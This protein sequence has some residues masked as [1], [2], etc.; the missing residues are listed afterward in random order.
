[1]L[2][3]QSGGVYVVSLVS[4]SQEDGSKRCFAPQLS[5][6]LIAEWLRMNPC[7]RLD[8]DDHRPTVAELRERLAA[9]WLPHEPVLYVGQT[10]KSLGERLS[11]YR[12]TPPERS[13]P[14]AGGYWLKLVAGYSS[15]FVFWAART[16]PNAAEKAMLDRFVSRVSR[17][18]RALLL[19]PL[20]PFPFANLEHPKG[21][22]KAHG[23]K[24]PHCGG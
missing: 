20:R 5:E 2:P 17:Q 23:I 8:S 13:R 24:H 6:E 11:A 15:K 22:V 7:L 12:R 9:F 16:D 21:N 3:S 1:M 10:S 14:H 19:D 18:T 4:E